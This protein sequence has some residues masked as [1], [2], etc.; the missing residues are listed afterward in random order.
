MSEKTQDE[1]QDIEDLEPGADVEAPEAEP[2]EEQSEIEEEAPEDPEAEEEAPEEAEE[3]AEPEAEEEDPL[4]I[5]RCFTIPA[6]LSDEIDMINNELGSSFSSIVRVAFSDPQRYR[7][8][9]ETAKK[10]EAG[11]SL[12]KLGKL[13]HER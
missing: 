3:E 6:D 9:L 4:T 7:V 11:M 5:R 10:L 13:A 8:L 1:L 2:D 12:E